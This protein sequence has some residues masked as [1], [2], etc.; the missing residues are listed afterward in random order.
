MEFYQKLLELFKKIHDSHR[1]ADALP[2]LESE[3]L[4]LFD[5]E[6]MTIYQRNR[7]SRDIVSRFKSGD[8][9]KEIRLPIGPQSLAGYVALSLRPLLIKDAYD[10]EALT[11]VH[12][13]LK[14]ASRYDKA[15]NFRTKSVLIVPIQDNGVLLGVVQFINRRDGTTFGESDARKA[16]E[17]SGLL[18]QKFRYELGGTKA[19]F[20]Y[21]YHLGAV[22]KEQL[23]VIHKERNVEE[24]L[25]RLREEFKV[26]KDLIGLSLEVYYQVPFLSHD[27]EKYHVHD[28]NN[29]LNLNYLQKNNVVVI[30]D[31]NEDPI[32]L[33]AQPNNGDLLLEIESATGI[34]DYSISVGLPEDVHR[35]LGTQLPSSA[36]MG[37]LGDILGEIEDDIMVDDSLK[38]DDSLNEEAPAVV[39]L[40]NRIL[41]DAVQIDASDIHIEPSKGKVPTQV[42]MRVD[43]V[44]QKVIEIPASHQPATA[45]RIKIMSRLDIAEKRLPQDGKFTVKLGNKPI[46][47]RV[48]TIPT[49]FGEGIVMRILATGDAMPYEKLAMSQHNYDMLDTMIRHPHGI[50]L[51]VG[52]TGS[53]KTTTLHAILGKLN[54]PEKKIW[55]AEDPVEITQPGLQQVQMN[56]RIGLDFAAALRAF[57][58]ADPDIILIGEMR[59]KETAH[60]GVE[61][62]LTGHLVLSTLHTNSA[63]ET[64]TRLLDIGL[65]PINFADAVIGILAQRLIR[66]LCKSCKETYRPDEKEKSFIRRHYGEQYID[67]LNI[68]WDN[69]ELKRAVGCPKC[70]Q[71]GYKGR[72]GIHELL[73]ISPINRNNIYNAENVGVIAKQGKKDGMRTLVQDGIIKVLMGLTDFK[74]L[75]TISTLD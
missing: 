55:T 48:A 33:M 6:R 32:I 23:E 37:E 11:A 62:S 26:A 65:D 51:V 31:V 70:A 34:I 69:L 63:P 67:E 8:E 45:A 41:H 3:I 10:A 19:P 43:G 36:N 53:G 75:Q 17:M 38:E 35:Y 27:E 22:V 9:I 61:A 18:A 74:Q 46:E 44:C 16:I 2:T 47:V 29:K 59:D 68:D 13:K 12:P 24:Q 30:A 60:A 15:T 71:S 64:I 21:L 57:L 50:L 54:T 1:F 73:P 56:S 5:A 39:K 72:A 40:V 66:T 20:D 7:Y 14:F 49:V 25:R 52:P 4:H 42:R 28:A 58:R